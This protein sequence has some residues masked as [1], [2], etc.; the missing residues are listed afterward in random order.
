MDVAAI[1]HQSLRKA[2]DLAGLTPKQLVEALAGDGGG[3]ISLQYACDI[4]SGRRTLKRN[5]T[6]RRRIAVAAGVPQHWIESQGPTGE[7]A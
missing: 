6:L 5:P 7:A 2:L 4:L 1:D 3:S